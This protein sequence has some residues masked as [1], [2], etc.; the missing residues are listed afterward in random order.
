VTA[1]VVVPPHPQVAINSVTTNSRAYFGWDMEI[2]N[3]A[4]GE[5]VLGNVLPF[6]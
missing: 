4:A 1:D 5:I 3:Y 2:F 6:G